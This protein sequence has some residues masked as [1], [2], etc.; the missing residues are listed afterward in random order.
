MR[1]ILAASLLVLLAAVACGD[2]IELV[3]EDLAGTEARAA[4]A[5]TVTQVMAKD[6]LDAYEANQFAANQKYEGRILEITGTI[7]SFGNIFGI[8]YLVLSDGSRRLEGIQCYFS[9]K[10]ANQLAALQ[11]GQTVIVRG[12][13]DGYYVINVGVS[14]CTVVS[15]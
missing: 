3:K 5:S 11:K 6:L 15:S 8:N 9:D 1:T 12:Q 2:Q 4:A 10:H 14:G 13:V 7:E